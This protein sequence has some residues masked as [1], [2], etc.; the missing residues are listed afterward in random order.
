M[1]LTPG[2]DGLDAYR[3]IAPKLKGALAPGGRAI[4]EFGAGQADAVKRIFDA[5]S[6]RF[7]RF[8]EDMGGRRRCMELA[9]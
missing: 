5:E 2:G 6:L 8:V 9:I 3:A 4:L 1:A 7:I